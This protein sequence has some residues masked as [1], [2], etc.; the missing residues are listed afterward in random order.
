MDTT[1]IQKPIVEA[2]KA[3]RLPAGS[4]LE[5]NGVHVPHPHAEVNL[6]G[7]PDPRLGDTKAVT[8]REVIDPAT[9][10][11]AVKQVPLAVEVK[12]KLATVADAK[13]VVAEKTFEPTSAEA[14][15]PADQHVAVEQPTPE[16]TV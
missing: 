16:K 7:V 11:V 12:P 15:K 4:T 13:P 14:A 5:V 2:G 8:E 10:S 1:S 3:S 9:G 6:P